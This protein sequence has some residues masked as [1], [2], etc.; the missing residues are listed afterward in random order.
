M[1]SM[2]CAALVALCLGAAP[3][4]PVAWK[5]QDA[6]AKPVKAGARFAVKLVAHIQDGWHMYGLKPIADGPIPT[7]IWV[8]E[9]QPAQLAAAVQGSEPVTMQDPSFNME[10]QL[11]EGEATFTMPLRLAAAAHEGAEKIVVNAS[12]QT[13]DNKICLPPKTVKV[14]V[15]VT[16]SK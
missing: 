14:E 2:I 8:A 15:P 1:R 10:V 9:G 12:Y 13:C 6:P 3:P 11:Y 16:V 4:D 5:V 7:R